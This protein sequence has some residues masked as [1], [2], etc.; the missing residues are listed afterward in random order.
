[1]ISLLTYCIP[2]DGRSANSPN[3]APDSG[4]SSNRASDSPL[5]HNLAADMPGAPQNS[6]VKVVYCEA[7]KAILAVFSGY[8]ARI[9]LYASQYLRLW[10]QDP[11][12][13]SQSAQE[14]VRMVGIRYLVQS[15]LEH[16]ML[17]DRSVATIENPPLIRGGRLAFAISIEGASLLKACL[18]ICDVCTCICACTGKGTQP[19]ISFDCLCVC[20]FFLHACL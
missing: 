6:R 10:P 2:T 5:P 3:A 13:P 15:D 11:A 9:A 20:S 7:Y 8:T 16:H 14:T 1:M 12:S 18:T 4:G 19:R 17:I